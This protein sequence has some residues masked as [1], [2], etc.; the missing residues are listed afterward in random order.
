MIF[1]RKCPG[2]AEEKCPE[3]CPLSS[4]YRIYSKSPAHTLMIDAI[5]DRVDKALEEQ[6]LL[7]VE[8]LIRK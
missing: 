6:S 4:D 1:Q 8:W 7:E 3:F 2:N 5:K